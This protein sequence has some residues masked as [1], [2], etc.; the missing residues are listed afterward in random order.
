MRA[1]RTL[2]IGLIAPAAV[3]FVA[4]AVW[5]RRPAADEPA[6]NERPGEPGTYETRFDAMGT[7]GR[8]QA[9]APGA[10]AARRMF[11]HALRE[12]RT[13]ED[14][15]STYKPASEV[16]RLNRLGADGPVVLSRDPMAVIRKSVEVARLTGGAFDVAYAP[17]RTLWRR[18]Q[19][20]GRVPTDADVRKTL[21]T[22][23]SDKLIVEGDTVRFGV[24]GM[25]VDLGGIAKGYAVDL[26]TGIL[27]REGAT[28]GIVDLGGNLRLFGEPPG[29]GKWRVEVN[30]PPG[31]TEDIIL[32]LPPCGIAT[33]GDY[34]RYFTVGGRRFSH[35][36]DPRTGWPVEAMPSVT[37]VAP[38]ATTADGLS[39]GVSVLGVKEGLAAAR[40]AP[41]VECM[42]MSRRPDGSLEKTMTPG[43]EKLID[44][45]TPLRPG[46]DAAPAGEAR[47]GG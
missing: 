38:D 16:S 18:A 40:K 39:T 17:L 21:E 13:L 6:V 28:A 7:R 37:I 4:A 33:S 8:F 44:S 25:E 19:N 45:V 12:V 5:L 30:P 15:M 29:G 10:A 2:W 26:A 31:A 1:N 36:I 42:I 20:D 14:L 9:A 11:G 32:A 22:V 27:Q 46:P 24:R 41:G 23:G 35:I 3:A 34:E 43:F 47:E